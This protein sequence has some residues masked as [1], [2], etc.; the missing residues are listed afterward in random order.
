MGGHIDGGGGEEGA[1]REDE[2]KREEQ[3]IPLGYPT[4]HHRSYLARVSDY[5]ERQQGDAG[6]VRRGRGEERGYR[7]TKWEAHKEHRD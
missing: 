5:N 1:D 4:N 7:R 6:E 3:Y 2:E